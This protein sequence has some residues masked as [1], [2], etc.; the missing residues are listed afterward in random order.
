LATTH[1]SII[2]YTVSAEILR[3][4]GLELDRKKFYRLQDKK[5]VE[6][7]T[8]K[9]KLQVLLI[10]LQDKGLYPCIQAEYIKTA[11]SNRSC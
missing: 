1:A 6:E 10:Y 2:S 5:A 11:G 8:R 4:E 7:L 9:D 3:K